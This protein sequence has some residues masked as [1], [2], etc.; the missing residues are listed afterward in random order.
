MKKETRYKILE[1][2]VCLITIAISVSFVYFLADNAELMKNSVDYTFNIPN[3]YNATHIKFDSSTYT[4]G[5][6]TYQEFPYKIQDKEQNETKITITVKYYIVSKSE[7]LSNQNIQTVPGYYQ[8][9]EKQYS[10][11]IITND[12]IPNALGLQVLV[13]FSSSSVIGII[14]FGIYSFIF[15]G[16]EGD[17]I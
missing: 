9:G 6:G 14:V 2:I 8:I 11:Q 16:D 13:I 10:L 15:P 1:L 5:A 7:E 4:I 3:E 12:N 17:E